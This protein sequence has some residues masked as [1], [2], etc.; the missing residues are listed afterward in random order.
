MALDNCSHRRVAIPRN[1]MKSRHLGGGLTGKAAIL[2]AHWE[3]GRLARSMDG[4]FAARATDE[5]SVVPFGGASTTRRLP[6][7]F[8]KSGGGARRPAEPLFAADSPHQSVTGLLDF[9]CTHLLLVLYT[10]KPLIH[11]LANLFLSL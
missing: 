5:T 8:A 3:N 7:H 1:R 10:C 4:P 9:E 6:P 11:P 2:A